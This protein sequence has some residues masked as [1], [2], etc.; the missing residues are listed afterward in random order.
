[1]YLKFLKGG[2]EGGLGTCIQIVD[3]KELMMIF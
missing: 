1:M 3:N 2:G